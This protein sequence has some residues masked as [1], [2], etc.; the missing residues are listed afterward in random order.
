MATN[1]DDNISRYDSS[2]DFWDEVTPLPTA[3]PVGSQADI[4]NRIK[5]LIPR[6]WFQASPNFDATLQGA[7]WA[8][9]SAYT[10]ITY[11]SLQTRIKTASDGFLDLISHDFFGTSLPRLTLETDSAFRSRIL[12]NLFVRGPTRA[13]M[14]KVL[15]LLTGVAPTI[16]EPGNTTDSGGW[17]GRFYWDAGTA[18]G[19]GWGDPLPYQSFVTVYR[20]IGNLISL[21][22]LDTVRFGFDENAYWSDNPPSSLTDAAIIAA[23]EATRAV[24]TV[25]WLRIVDAPVSP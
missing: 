1:W 12:A 3:P 19:G 7:S 10:R 25:I 18:V 9:S 20:P 24:G 16:F 15:T 22:E 14:A 5:T 21:A 6:S 4:F 8:L 2:F 13:D 23:V 11:A 17:G